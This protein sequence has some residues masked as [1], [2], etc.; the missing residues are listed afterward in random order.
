MATA[1]LFCVGLLGEPEQGS[2]QSPLAC[3]RVRGRNLI[4]QQSCL[5]EHSP[6]PA[7]E[8]GALHMVGGV[9]GL[10]VQWIAK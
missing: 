8:P 9:W 1:E 5:A 10:G 6:F 3:C 7:E 4:P 2:L